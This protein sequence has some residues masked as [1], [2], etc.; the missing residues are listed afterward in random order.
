[1][2]PI[3][4]EGSASPHRAI[5]VLQKNFTTGNRNK[6]GINHKHP[7][8]REG[9]DTWPKSNLV[10]CI[11]HQMTMKIIAGISRIDASPGGNLQTFF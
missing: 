6:K 8:K 9:K 1:M 7:I 11:V 2:M 4:T 3:L 5:N 10:P